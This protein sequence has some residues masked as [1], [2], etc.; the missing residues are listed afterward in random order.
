MN[1]IATIKNRRTVADL[2]RKLGDIPPERVWLR[3][4]PGTATEEDVLAVEA[5]ENRLCELIDGVLV[6]KTVG[7][8]ECLLAHLI[9]YYL[10]N[11][12]EEHDLGIVLGADGM[13][14]ILVG[15]V[16]IPDVCFIPWSRLPER[17]FP[18]EPI[19]GLVPAL[20]VEVLSPSNTP[21]EMKRKLQEYFKAGVL[22]VWYV[23]PKNRTAKVYSSPRKGK[24]IQEHE[25]LDGG[26][27]LPGFSL[28]LRKLFA[29]ADRK[30]R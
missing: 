3:P 1:M 26:S 22:V 29:R 11:F 19:P 21:K 30:G 16:R 28:P 13:L 4:T 17:R 20:A 18:K 14:R 10:E 15:Q 23:D 6:E 5:K 2:L 12:L 8:Y 9:G 27:V 7:A 25:A 24:L